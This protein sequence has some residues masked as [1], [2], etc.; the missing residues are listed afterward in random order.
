MALFPNT[1]DY[2]KED[3][4]MLQNTAIKQQLLGVSFFKKC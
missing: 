4:T 3:L 2:F 1:R